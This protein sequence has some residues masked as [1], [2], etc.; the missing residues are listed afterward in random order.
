[1]NQDTAQVYEYPV[2]TGF[3]SL[4][5]ASVL[6]YP[7]PA[8]D[9]IY[10]TANVNHPVYLKI[11]DALGQIHLQRNY[12]S[13]DALDVS[14]LQPGMYLLYIYYYRELVSIK[15]IIFA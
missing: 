5:S 2:V 10:I 6:I 13:G 9:F 4:L 11:I 1:L 12:I 7:N 8:H 15:K 3:N 14:A